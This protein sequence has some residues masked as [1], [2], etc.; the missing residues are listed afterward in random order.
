M[1]PV[2]QQVISRLADRIMEETLATKTLTSEE[3]AGILASYN[4]VTERLKQSHDVL[5]GEVR[6][7]RK[8]LASKNRQLEQRKRLAA[9]GEMAAGLAHEIRNPLGGIRLYADLLRRDLSD[10]REQV[11]LIDRIIDGVRGMDGLVTDVLS[12]T[13]TIEPKF[14]RSDLAAIVSSSLGLLGDVVENFDTEITFQSPAEFELDCDR[15]M[16]G[17]A[18]LN[19]LRNAAEAAGKN[20][21]VTVDVFR[22]DGRAVIEIGDSGSGIASEIA[23]KMFNPFFTTKDQGTG[24]GLSIVHRIIDAHDGTISVGRGNLGGALFTVKLPVKRERN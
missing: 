21:R 18:M 17:R 22:K 15:D 12:M 13:H 4:E 16:L 10:R 9:L 8:E 19:L 24:L 11:E 20:G 6:R 7:L 3:L 23:D 1:V 2:R 5:Q 14:G